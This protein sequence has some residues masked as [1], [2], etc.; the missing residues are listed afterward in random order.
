[1]T[2]WVCCCKWNG[3]LRAR[4]AMVFRAESSPIFS[5]CAENPRSDA[6]ET[7][8]RGRPFSTKSQFSSIGPPPVESRKSLILKA[9]YLNK[10]SA[11]Y[12]TRL[13]SRFQITLPPCRKPYSLLLVRRE[14]TD[15]TSLLPLEATTPGLK[16]E[17]CCSR[18]A[19]I[20]LSHS[21][22]PCQRQGNDGLSMTQPF[23]ILQTSSHRPLLDSTSSLPPIDFLK[24]HVRL[25]FFLFPFCFVI[26][27][28]NLASFL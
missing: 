28:L 10:K 25:G 1:M 15:R 24:T 16:G 11:Q 13:F 4:L 3:S 8:E 5:A 19:A 14:A 6:I 12:S 23:G 9:G 21:S 20:G 26:F 2:E 22:L 17:G 18:F 7:E 27:S